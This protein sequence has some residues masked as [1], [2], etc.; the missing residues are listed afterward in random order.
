M[1]W[2]FLILAL[3]GLAGAETVRD[4]ASQALLDK[5]GEL[6]EKGDWNGSA[7]LYRDAARR[8]VDPAVSWFNYGN[9]QAQLK[10]TGEAAA[11]WTRALEWA[12]RFLR[13]RQNLA[14][15]AEDNRDWGEAARQWR[16]LWDIDSTDPDPA[17]RLGEIALESENP[18]DAATWFSRAIGADSTSSAGHLGL[19]RALLAASDTARAV[20]ALDLF[21]P[22]TLSDT[23]G[24]LSLALGSLYESC[25]SWYRAE[26]C[27]Q[28]VLAVAPRNVQA[29]L[30][31]A[32]LSQLRRRDGEAVVVLRQS[33]ELIPD[34]P[35]LWKALGQA[36]ARAGDAKTAVDGYAKALELG[37]AT[38]KPGLRTIAGWLRARGERDL[39]ARADSLSR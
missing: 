33:L 23:T 16:I 32:R 35:L 17:V 12:P 34:S 2:L 22:R 31:L 10:K 20:E 25:E 37:D 24:R 30:R 29:W 38:A 39:A 7:A 28:D 3:A 4:S 21:R 36:S 27:Y 8:G 5:A 26:E 18:A 15:L 1:K 6:Y 13:A 14:I 9:C 11:A 19:A